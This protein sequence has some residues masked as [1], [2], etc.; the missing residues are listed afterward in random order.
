MKATLEG[1]D[2]VDAGT[3]FQVKWSGPDNPRD[4]VAIGNAARAYITYAYTNAGNPVSLVAPDQAGEYELRYIL[5]EGDTVIGT[6]PIVIGG[7]TRNGRRTG[8]GRGGQQV[9]GQVDG[10]G[11]S[12]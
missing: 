8:H 11:Q 4:Y 12:A 3:K 1:P 7:V 9:P 10:A 5:A 6:R 2:R